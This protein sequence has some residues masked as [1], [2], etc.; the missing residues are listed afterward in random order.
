MK[1]ELFE[2]FLKAEEFIWKRNLGASV[3]TENTELFKNDDITIFIWFPYPSLDHK[4]KLT[5]DCC[6]FKFLQSN[7]DDLVGRIVSPNHV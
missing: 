5:A 4:S 3:C 1:T 7:L 2:N 6:L